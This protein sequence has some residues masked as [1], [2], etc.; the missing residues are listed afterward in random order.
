MIEMV[1]ILGESRHHTRFM[2]LKSSLSQLLYLMV[3]SQEY[4]GRKKVKKSTSNNTI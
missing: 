1:P 4:D 2:Y 3:L